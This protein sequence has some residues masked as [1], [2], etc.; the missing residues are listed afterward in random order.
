MASTSTILEELK[1]PAYPGAKLD[2]EIDLPQGPV[3]DKI[4]QEFDPMLAMTTLK[5]V[6]VATFSI[7]S[8]AQ[9]T[10]VIKFYEPKLKDL[11]WTPSVRR[12]ER[13]GSAV[14]TLTN[15]KIGMLI[16][17]VDNSDATD[18]NLTVIRITGTL[19]ERKLTK[20]VAGPPQI[21]SFRLDPGIPTSQPIAIAPSTK[22]EIQSVGSAISAH[23]G[24]P[25]SVQL[26]RSSDNARV[27]EMSRTGDGR[28]L[29]TLAPRLQLDEIILPST[30]PVIFELN[31][32][33]LSL[34]GTNLNSNALGIV[35]ENASVT[36]Q[37]LALVSGKHSVKVTDQSAS[38]SLSEVTG[39]IFAIDV[40]GGDVTLTMP[41][42]ASALLD[43][44]AA[45]EKT[46]N[47]TGVN[48]LS[49][50]NSSMRLK[51]G[52]GGA[53]ISVKSTGTV[54]IKTL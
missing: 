12:V 48:A 43:I 20:E 23:A 39:G 49:S 34:T 14:W 30:V 35:A 41:K 44:S 5:Q 47:E 17:T 45:A 27:G 13:S 22:L 18:R 46:K 15:E 21:E 36:L 10:D 54:T 11:R 24:S 4:K 50:T 32:G 31:G 42:N 16:F 38:V 6:S 1:V 8:S 37:N 51:L 26:T 33:S 3:L 52:D 53:A 29:I 7:D 9:A 28:L 25:D 19:D 2:S 40:Q